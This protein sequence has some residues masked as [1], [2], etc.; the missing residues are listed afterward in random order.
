MWAAPGTGT[1]IR[2]PALERVDVIR[3]EQMR[4]HVAAIVED[5]ETAEALKHYYRYF[6]KRPTF[7]AGYYESFN[8]PN[9]TLIDTDGRGLDR[10]TEH[11]IVFDDHE[12]QVHCIVITSGYE[13]DADYHIRS[14]FEIVGRNGLTLAD[15]WANGGRRTLYCVMTR[16][17]PNLFLVGNPLHS[18][19]YLNFTSQLNEQAKV[20]QHL[21]EHTLKSG[22][23]IVEPSQNAEDAFVD[24]V[25]RVAVRNL[26]F[27]QACTP[28]QYNDYG[29]SNER[30]PLETGGYGLGPVVWEKML[31]DWRDDGRCEGFAFTTARSQ[32]AVTP[33][34]WSESG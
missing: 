7:S 17:F 6:C 1:G 26:D 25:R 22:H 34:S 29:A 15:R 9:V 23:E 33:R 12:Y 5:P 14:G 30:T 18:A 10:I 21:V 8:R 16:E 19:F 32:A 3:D 31:Q 13:A 20:M 2:A 4:R 11:G 24:E 27:Q 28:G